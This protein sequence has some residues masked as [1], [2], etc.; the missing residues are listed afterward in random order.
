VSESLFAWADKWRTPDGESRDVRRQM[1]K[2]NDKAR[3]TE[4]KQWQETV[5]KLASFCKVLKLG[6]IVCDCSCFV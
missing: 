2:E 1:K 4:K 5:R 6:M 3:A